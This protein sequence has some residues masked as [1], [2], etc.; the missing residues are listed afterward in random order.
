MD[1]QKSQPTPTGRSAAA[2]YEP[3]PPPGE[4]L[5]VMNL[6]HRNQ[7]QYDR[8]DFEVE[9]ENMDVEQMN[10]KRKKGENGKGTKGV[11]KKKVKKNTVEIEDLLEDDD[12]IET[13]VRY[14]NIRTH[15]SSQSGQ[16]KLNADI[17]RRIVPIK[18]RLL[19]GLSQG[20]SQNQDASENDFITE[21]QVHC[22]DQQTTG[23]STP[24][25]MS[26]DNPNEDMTIFAKSIHT[27]LT[28]INPIR[29][30]NEVNKILGRQVKIS[31]S[32]VSLRIS[33]ENE[34]EKKKIRKHTT[35]CD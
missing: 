13:N 3:I 9:V 29:I 14:E 5:Y 20:I 2:L 30:Q 18:I 24:K 4:W 31:K 16:S 1:A 25:G 19:P 7:A 33:C 32:G 27:N 15:Q 23:M 11:Q 21:G 35:M 10:N 22:D 26:R 34:A 28:K 12:P 17:Q 8:K 6:T